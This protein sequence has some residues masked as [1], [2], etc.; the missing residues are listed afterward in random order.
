MRSV[1]AAAVMPMEMVP[2]ALVGR[3]QAA[4]SAYSAA[5]GDR[6][7]L[8][9]LSAEVAAAWREM[10]AVP[11]LG[12]WLVA[13]LSAAAEAF[14]RQAQDWSRSHPRARPSRPTEWQTGSHRQGGP[15]VDQLRPPVSGS[16][17]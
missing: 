7:E 6:A 8:A 11:G 10:A 17:T 12:W 3:W 5:E 1:R 13:A 15:S 14:E 9:R 2:D 16:V 4:Y